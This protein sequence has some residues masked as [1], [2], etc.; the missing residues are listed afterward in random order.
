MMLKTAKVIKSKSISGERNVVFGHCTIT[1]IPPTSFYFVTILEAGEEITEEILNRSSKFSGRQMCCAKEQA[2]K[3][4]DKL[5]MEETRAFLSSE[6]LI[7]LE[8]AKEEAEQNGD[9]V[10]AEIFGDSEWMITA[11]LKKVHEQDQ[12]I[13]RLEKAA[14]EKTEVISEVRRKLFEIQ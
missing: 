2:L 1:I 8:H 6:I 4:F 13:E 10:S 11:L 7:S 14:A 12:K 9:T 3:A 5:V